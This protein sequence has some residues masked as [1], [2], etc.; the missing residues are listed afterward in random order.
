MRVPQV[1]LQ[2]RLASSERDWSDRSEQQSATLEASRRELLASRS[3]AQAATDD[4]DRLAALLGESQ[5][6]HQAAALQLTQ[7]EA[8][9]K[10]KVTIA[11]SSYRRTADTSQLGPDGRFLIIKLFKKIVAIIEILLTSCHHR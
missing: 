9:L 2:Q 3:G 6:L 11:V 8:Q 5:R 7:S 4:R 10:T 1:A